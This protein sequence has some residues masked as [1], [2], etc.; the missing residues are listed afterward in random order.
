MVPERERGVIGGDVGG[1]DEDDAGGGRESGFGVGGGGGMVTGQKR[2]VAGGG[3]MV[4]RGENVPVI[5]R[6]NVSGGGGGT[7]VDSG[8]TL[9]G[10]R[11]DE[12]G[13]KAG[14]W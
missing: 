9:R 14:L 2:G 7:D 4:D 6:E 3:G 10:G 5:V 13:G 12:D 8:G 11:S 1:N